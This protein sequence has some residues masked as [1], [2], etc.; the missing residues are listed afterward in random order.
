MVEDLV[1]AVAAFRLE[2]LLAERGTGAVAE[3]VFE[4]E[5]VAAFDAHRG[6]DAE[7]SVPMPGEHV[8]GGV[9]IDE[10]VAAEVAEHPLA[11]GGS[12]ALDVGQREGVGLEEAEVAVRVVLEEAVGDRQASAP[13]SGQRLRRLPRMA[14]RKTCSTVPASFGLWWRKGR[15]RLG[16]ERTHWR[17]GS[18]GKIRSVR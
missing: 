12:E 18:T 15:R 11:D 7:A 4:A 16:T 10:A 9:G 17:T 2:A 5:A 6:I 1:G 13:A 8:V 3:E 14:R